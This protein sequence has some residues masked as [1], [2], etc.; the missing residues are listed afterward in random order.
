M[1]VPSTD[2]KIQ[3]RPFLVKEEKILLIAMESGKSEDIIEAVK[4]IVSSCTFDKL[5]FAISFLFW[6][7]FNFLYK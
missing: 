3:F 5:S 1:E 2:E 4:Q 7:L 6:I